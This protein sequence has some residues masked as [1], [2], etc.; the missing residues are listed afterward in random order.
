MGAPYRP[1]ATGAG[2]GTAARVPRQRSCGRLTRR[3]V[4]RPPRMRSRA[5]LPLSPLPRLAPHRQARLDTSSSTTPVIGRATK[6]KLA[7]VWPTTSAS[8]ATRTCPPSARAAATPTLAQPSPSTAPPRGHRAATP[9]P[10]DSRGPLARPRVMTR[11]AAAPAPRRPP[12]LLP[13]P[14]HAFPACP[15]TLNLLPAFTPPTTPHVPRRPLPRPPRWRRG[16]T[17]PLLCAP[18]PHSL[19]GR[20]PPPPP[21][22]VP[23]LFSPALGARPAQGGLS[24]RPAPPPPYRGAP[25]CV[26]GL[27]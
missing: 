18:P 21:P 20:L 11:R 14:L 15:S 24:P 8:S 1:T 16:L 23:D 17:C 7:D 26:A 19:L 10:S 22:P 6:P 5:R 3:T 25:A 2:A 9:T 13:T 4:H 27:A 12:S